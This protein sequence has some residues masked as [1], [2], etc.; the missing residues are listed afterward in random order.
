MRRCR[1]ISVLVSKAQEQPLVW[2]ERLA[3]ALHLSICSNC[4]KFRQQ[5]QFLGRAALNY[6]TYLDQ[7]SKKR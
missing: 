6:R 3:V 2:Y 1:D 7:R 4:R 5:T